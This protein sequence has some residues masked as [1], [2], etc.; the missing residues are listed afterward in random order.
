MGVNIYVSNQVGIVG[1]SSSNPDDCYVITPGAVAAV[2]QIDSFET[3]RP[4]RRFGDA[5]KG[6]M[7]YGSKV[8]DGDR[9]FRYTF[10][11]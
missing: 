2:V 1:T 9:L 6:L 10:P 7:V 3:Y 5:Y 4:E 11:F 8:L